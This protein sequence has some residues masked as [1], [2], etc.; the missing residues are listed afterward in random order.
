MLVSRPVSFETKQYETMEI[1]PEL[2]ANDAMVHEGV[3]YLLLKEGLSPQE[4]RNLTLYGERNL[5]PEAVSKDAVNPTDKSRMTWKQWVASQPA[6]SKLSTEE[7]IQEM[8]VQILDALALNQIPKEKSAGAV[9]NIKR[10]L[11]D[12][13]TV[14]TG[15]SDTGSLASIASVYNKM[16]D[17]VEVARRLQVAEES[18]L[19]ELRF[20]D[21]ANENDLRQLVQAIKNKDQ[22]EIKKISNTDS[23]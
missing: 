19:A 12:L 22:E 7:K 21:R 2:L 15:V 8:Q 6:Y 1:T 20:V 23:D 18:G 3:H 16:Q 11:A 5:V 13:V 9:G 17:N 10:R 4:I 14:L